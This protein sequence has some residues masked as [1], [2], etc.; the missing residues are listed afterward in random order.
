MKIVVTGDRNWTCLET[1]NYAIQWVLNKYEIRCRE[2]QLVE[3]ECRGAD[4]GCRVVAEAMG[5][6]VIPEPAEWN[7]YHR[8]AGVIR[9]QRMLDNHPDL[10]LC[11][12]FHDNL[13]ES[14]GTK[15]MIGKCK[16]KKLPVYHFKTASISLSPILL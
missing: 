15:D 16:K 8:A 11:L 12:A 4:L 2:L 1:I 7:K 9:N 3:G 6:E 5:I 14:K 10:E 13:K